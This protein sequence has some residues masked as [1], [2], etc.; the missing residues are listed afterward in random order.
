M[1]AEPAPTKIPKPSCIN[2][3]IQRLVK[4]KSNREKPGSTREI[5]GDKAKADRP[6]KISEITKAMIP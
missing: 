2:I 3:K 4:K 1:W 5:F 6:A